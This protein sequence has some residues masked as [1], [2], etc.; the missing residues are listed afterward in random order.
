ML[1]ALDC[2]IERNQTNPK[3]L[4]MGLGKNMGVWKITKNVLEIVMASC[5]KIT[6]KQHSQVHRKKQNQAIQNECS[7]NASPLQVAMGKIVLKKVDRWGWD[8]S[9]LGKEYLKN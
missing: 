9:I 6:S 5:H 2:L 8:N 1:V 3:R 4:Y 7:A